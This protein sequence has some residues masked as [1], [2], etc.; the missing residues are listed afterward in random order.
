MN[1]KSILAAAALSV[2]SVY[3]SASQ[4]STECSG[5]LLAVFVGDGGAAY[6][7]LDSGVVGYFVNSDPNQKGGLAVGTA[8]LLAG[9]AVGLRFSANAADCSKYGIRGDL[10]GIWLK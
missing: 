4:A 2:V 7:F 1:F 3:P 10:V 5:K 9:R 6:F 8:A